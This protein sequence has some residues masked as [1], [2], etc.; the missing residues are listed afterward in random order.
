M[1]V[2]EV[3]I[4]LGAQFSG[5]CEADFETQIPPCLRAVLFRVYIKN[6]E[7]NKSGRP[8]TVDV[9]WTTATGLAGHGTLDGTLPVI[10]VN[11]FQSRRF[12]VLIPDDGTAGFSSQGAVCVGV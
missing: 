9:S 12:S 5:Y 4:R 1:N 6:D 7:R 2:P 8:L 3:G 11:Q 10:G